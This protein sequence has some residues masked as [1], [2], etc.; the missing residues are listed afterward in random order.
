[1]RAEARFT[2]EQ[3][4]RDQGKVF[5]L[6]EM[7]ATQAERW[8]LRALWG[9][10]ATGTELPEDFL[11]LGLPG[12]AQLGFRAFLSMPWEIAR[13]LTDEMMDC[14]QIIRDPGG[15]A[16]VQ[17]V[18]ESDIEEVETRLRLKAAVF[19]LHT[20]FSMAAALTP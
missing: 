1:M 9:M 20:G 18:L 6:T 19:Q 5:L 7:S 16:L 12:L 11:T 17:R 13:P 10:A 15:A 2:V 4:N 8:A 14:I 3:D